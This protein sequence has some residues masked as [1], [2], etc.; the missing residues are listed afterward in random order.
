MAVLN[1]KENT[2]CIIT[3]K[4]GCDDAIHFVVDADDPNLYMIATLVESRFYSEQDNKISRVIK[5]KLKKIWAI[6]RNKDYY[7]N[8]IVMSK[9][10][11][12]EFKRFLN[13]F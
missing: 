12:K 7:L 13:R 10:E 6:I 2:E 9:D 3:C 4:C 1:N 5:K 11:F 8:E